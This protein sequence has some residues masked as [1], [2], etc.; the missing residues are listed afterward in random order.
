[1]LVRD[2]PGAVLARQA[3]GRQTLDKGRPEFFPARPRR[4]LSVGGANVGS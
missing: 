3:A 1:M 4:L 2:M